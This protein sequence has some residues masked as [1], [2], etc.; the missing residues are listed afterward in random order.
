MVQWL[1]VSVKCDD[2]S[3]TSGT[4]KEKELIPKFNSFSNEDHASLLHTRTH[5]HNLKNGLFPKTTKN[6]A[7]YT[8]FTKY[9]LNIQF[10]DVTNVKL[11]LK[12]FEFSYSL[13]I[14][15]T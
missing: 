1:K 14:R 15:N 8:E 13:E 12:I 7:Q 5:K 11:L 3:L 4:N 6:Q 10:R 9:D 2:L